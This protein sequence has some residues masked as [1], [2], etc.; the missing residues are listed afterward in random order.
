[1]APLNNSNVTWSKTFKQDTNTQIRLADDVIDMCVNFQNWAF[2]YQLVHFTYNVHHTFHSEP[3][4]CTSC[5]V[6]YRPTHAPLLTCMPSQST[7]HHVTC[8]QNDFLSMMYS[9]SIRQSIDGASTCVAPS[10]D[11]KQVTCMILDVDAKLTSGYNNVDGVHD[12]PTSIPE[13]VHAIQR[14][15]KLSFRLLC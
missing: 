12:P 7:I 13:V 11:N 4:H 3:S 6:I 1:M 15:N 2:C 8:C 10:S 5:D 9:S 14:T